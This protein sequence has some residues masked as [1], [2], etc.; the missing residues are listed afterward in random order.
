MKT[1]RMKLKTF[2]DLFGLGNVAITGEDNSF[3]FTQREEYI[4]AI[5]DVLKAA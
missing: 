5:I 3:R 4:F 2:K 1:L